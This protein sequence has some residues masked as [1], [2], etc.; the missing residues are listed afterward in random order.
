MFRTFVRVGALLCMCLPGWVLAQSLPRPAEFYFD[1]DGGVAAPIVAIEGSDDATIDALVAQMERGR[2]NAD[3]AAAQLARLS[4][5][6]GRVETG[7][8][9]Y[10]RAENLASNTQIRHAIAWNRGWDLYRIGDLQGALEQW[11]RASSGRGMIRPDWAPP[12]LA[13]VLWKLD[14]RVE[15]VAWYAAAVR[16][17]PDRWA[18]DASL[19]S[20]LPDWNEADRATLAEVLAAWRANPP[21]WP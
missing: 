11:I 14:R 18:H 15:A 13:L 19:P 1:E 10:D 6:S 9:L 5:A 3:R 12:T 16:T 17:Y 4:I 2:R 21:A 8:A 7:H 20:L